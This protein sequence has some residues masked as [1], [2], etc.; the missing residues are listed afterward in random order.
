MRGCIEIFLKGNKNNDAK[1]N[2]FHCNILNEILV[3]CAF[4]I[5]F[6]EIKMYDT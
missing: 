1:I 6:G 5:I 4:T 3:G 2:E